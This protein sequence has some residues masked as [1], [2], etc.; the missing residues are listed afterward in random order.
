[1]AADGGQPSSPPLPLIAAVVRRRFSMSGTALQNKPSIKLWCGLRD[2]SDSLARVRVLSLLA[3]HGEG[4]V[5]RSAIVSSYL[6]VQRCFLA[7]LSKNSLSNANHCR[8][9]YTHPVLLRIA[10]PLRLTLPWAL[11]IPSGTELLLSLGAL[12]HSTSSIGFPH[13]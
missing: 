6:I 3:K 10:L 8:L 5:V 2:F 12:L 9:Y 11:Q 13:T 7:S 1:M 4:M